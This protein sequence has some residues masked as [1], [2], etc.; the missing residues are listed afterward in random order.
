MADPTV[1]KISSFLNILDEI[2][3]IGLPECTGGELPNGR[4]SLGA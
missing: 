1:R 4:V 3:D 2:K